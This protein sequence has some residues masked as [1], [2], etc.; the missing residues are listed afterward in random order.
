VSA[1]NDGFEDDPTTVPGLTEEELQRELA[2]DFMRERGV[3]TFYEALEMVRA[4]LNKPD[5]GAQP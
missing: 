1:V 4:A 2:L 3:K 5:T